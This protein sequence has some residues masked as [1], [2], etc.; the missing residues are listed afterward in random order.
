MSLG[1]RICCCVTDSAKEVQFVDQHSTEEV[2]AAW[3]VQ[4]QLSTVIDLDHKFLRYRQGTSDFEPLHKGDRP[5]S[6][7]KSWGRRVS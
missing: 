5:S 2:R 3:K 6:T 7:H 4:R 1:R